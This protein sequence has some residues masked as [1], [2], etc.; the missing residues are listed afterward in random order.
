M[1]GPVSETRDDLFSLARVRA[2]APLPRKTT[3]IRCNTCARGSCW[4]FGFYNAAVMRPEPSPARLA[5][6]SL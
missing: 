1:L 4:G 6:V 5:R 2:G 3:E